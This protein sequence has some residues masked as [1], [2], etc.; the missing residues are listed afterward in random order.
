MAAEKAAL[1]DNADYNPQP[2][3]QVPRRHAIEQRKRDLDHVE[4]LEIRLGVFVRWTPESPEWVAAIKALK[5]L[6][7]Q[8]ALD[9]V[10]RVVVEQLFEM[11]KAN[12]SGTGK[13]SL[14]RLSN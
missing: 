10:E 13:S 14:W 1:S 3:S 2:I 4:D 7:Y 9:T 5:E 12:Q 6:Q 8:E 11:T